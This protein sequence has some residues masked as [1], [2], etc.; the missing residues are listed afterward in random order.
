MGRQ[1]AFCIMTGVFAAVLLFLVVPGCAPTGPVLL[2][3][4]A[5]QAPEGTKPAGRKTVVAVAPFQDQR[6]K[7]ASVIGKR[8]I[9]D[10]VE[11][12]LV[13]Q[14]TAA[15]LIAASFKDALRSRGIPVK[16]AP[17]G[18]EA[19]GAAVP[20][21][22]LVLSGEIKTFWVD[23]RS[24]ALKAETKATVQLR[25]VLAEGPERKVF[26]TVTL[27]SAIERQDVAFSFETVKDALS[28]ALTGAVNQLL[29]DEEFKKRIN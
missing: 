19:S 27:N 12:D 29:A 11:N 28:E 13:V 15:D 25:A 24:Q 18:A 21:A 20:A 14:G 22:D 26:R 4:V 9:P 3:G 17:A 2:D 23:V 7:T 10:T 5:Y 16:D 6:G 1:S 8:T